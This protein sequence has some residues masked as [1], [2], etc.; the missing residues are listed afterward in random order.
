MTHKENITAI[1][2]CYFTGF[3][4]EI[5]DSA[6]NRILDQES[7]ED[8]VNKQKLKEQMLKYGFHAPDMTVTEFV[9]DLPPI[10][11]K[12]NPDEW[13]QNCKE[14]DHDKHCCPRFNR[15]IR[16]TV[17][18]I[19]QPKIGHWIFD[20]ILDRNYYCSECKSMGADYWDYC[21]YCGARMVEPQE[22]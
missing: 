12:Y 20:E 15:V 3:K 4:K 2:E 14:Y 5:I 1:L 18:E 11:P 6:C 13:C 21:P 8:I 22:R 7:W 17:E 9:E 19:K 10:Q 16:N